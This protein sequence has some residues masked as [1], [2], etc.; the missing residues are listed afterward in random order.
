M[1]TAQTAPDVAYSYI[2]FSTPAQAEGD[3][4]RRQ[5]E[6]AAAYCAKNNL[7]LDTSLTLRDLGVSAFRGKNAAVGSLRTFLDAMKETS[8]GKPARV[9]PGSVLIVENF[10][11]ISRQGI[12]EGY[13]LVK[14][15]LKAGVVIVTLYPERRFDREAT[16]SLSKGALEIQLI[17]ERAAEES[18]RKSERVGKAWSNKRKLARAGGHILTKK[19]PAWITH[20][21]GK[22]VLI[23]EKA[24]AVR[25]LFALA[26]SGYGHS[27]IVE[28]MKEDGVPPLSVKPWSRA[29]VGK[30]L[31]DRQAI[32]ELTPRTQNGKADGPPIPGYYPRVVSDREFNLAR[33]GAS[34][35]RKNPGRSGKNVNIFAGLLKQAGYGASFY[36]TAVNRP[37]AGGKTNRVALLSTAESNQ[38]HGVSVRYELFERDVLTHL[39]EIDPRELFGKSPAADE[40]TELEV[41]LERV[42]ESIAAIN[43]EMDEHGE[44][45]SLFKR[46]REK[47][48]K[49][50]ELTT[51]LA[52]AKERAAMPADRAFGELQTLAAA[53]ANAEDPRE[54]RLKLRSVIRRSVEEMHLLVVARGVLRVCALQVNFRDTNVRRH[55]VLAYRNNQ[56]L[57][58][59]SKAW[60]AG[61]SELDLK[62]ASHAQ[63]FEKDLLRAMEKAAKG[64][65]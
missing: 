3:S 2:R 22:L 16:K 58:A 60:A 46:L 65:D 4:L 32:G 41:E 33:A 28:K 10:D 15:I 61:L 51:Q 62:K 8:D 20:R 53:V 52:K 26:A 21:D 57:P 11:R 9:K 54:V 49:Q 24:E 1:K 55:Y 48:A 50:K 39:R 45:A 30:I 64:K 27:L 38:G 56:P 36:Y 63:R 37:L 47:E 42:E 44:S 34:Q 31:R 19:L 14:S 6:D 35:R 25:Q 29:Y 12:D 17:L 40:S 5:T 13:D 43:A 23:P 18:E 59:I 7:T